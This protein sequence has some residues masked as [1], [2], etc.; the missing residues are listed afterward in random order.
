MARLTNQIY[1]LC[2]PATFSIIIIIIYYY[3]LFW[4]SKWRILFYLFI[5]YDVCERACV[6]KYRY[7][8]VCMLCGDQRLIWVILLH[9]GSWGR[10]FLWMWNLGVWLVPVTVSHQATNSYTGAREPSFCSCRCV[11]C[12]FFTLWALLLIWGTFYLSYFW[13]FL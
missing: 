6:C 4:C 10:V 13:I 12:V 9:F 3:L 1:L 8:S 11:A 5:L 2:F 7:T